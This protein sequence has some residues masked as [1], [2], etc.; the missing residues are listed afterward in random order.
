MFHLLNDYLQIGTFNE[1]D[2]S[3]WTLAVATVLVGAL[4]LRRS[5]KD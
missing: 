2:P 1:A 5:P 3:G 4:I